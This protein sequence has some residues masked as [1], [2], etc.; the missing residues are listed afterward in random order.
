MATVKHA[1]LIHFDSLSLLSKSLL[2]ADGLKWA[3]C[4]CTGEQGL[5]IRDS[6]SGLFDPC[7]ILLWTVY[8]VPWASCETGGWKHIEQIKVSVA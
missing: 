6:F 8:A 2:F 1:D 3:L 4:V 7:R 5:C